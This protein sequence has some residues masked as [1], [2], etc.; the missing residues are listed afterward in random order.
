MADVVKA[1]DEPVEPE[2]TKP[3]GRPLLFE[4]VD[5]LDRQINSQFDKCDPHIEER[6]ADSGINQRTET[7]WAKGVSI[8]VPLADGRKACCWA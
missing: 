7:I 8:L 6:L 2:E 3:V 4:S 5:E 1:V